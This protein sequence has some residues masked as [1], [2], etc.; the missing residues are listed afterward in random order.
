MCTHNS[1]HTYLFAGGSQSLLSDWGS[2]QNVQV[3]SQMKRDASRHCFSTLCF[4][5]IYLYVIRTYPLPGCWAASEISFH[6]LQRWIIRY[7]SNTSVKILLRDL[8]SHL[9]VSP[10]IMTRWSHLQPS[11]IL[12]QHSGA[13]VLYYTT[14]SQTRRCWIPFSVWGHSVW[15]FHVSLVLHGFSLGVFLPQSTKHA[16][17]VN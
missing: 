10:A 13:V 7:V 9:T 2:R 5:F 17:Y 14:A 6:M 16:H 11:Q 12:L 3:V 8:L 1:L 15:S 4:S